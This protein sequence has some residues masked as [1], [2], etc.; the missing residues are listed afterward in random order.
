MFQLL[1]Q[2]DQIGDVEGVE[3]PAQVS[4]EF[5]RDDGGLFRIGEAERLDGGKRII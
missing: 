5:F 1:R 4:A 3:V 2:R